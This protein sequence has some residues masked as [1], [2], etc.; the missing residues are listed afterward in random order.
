MAAFTI[1]KRVE[2]TLTPQVKEALYFYLF[3]VLGGVTEEDHKQWK[4]L[5]AKINRLEAGEIINFEAIF[6]RNAKFHR[7]FFALLNFA[8]EAWEPE[9]SHKSYK[10]RPI[11]KNF[12]RFR[13]DVIVYAGYYEQTFDLKGNMKLEPLSMSFAKMDQPEFELLYNAVATVILENVLSNYK[14]RN[15]LDAVIEQIIGFL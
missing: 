9:R 15:E 1:T 10:G 7:K 14:D 12:E 4:R 2:I 8:F 5:W 11:T 3:D 6:P 13:K